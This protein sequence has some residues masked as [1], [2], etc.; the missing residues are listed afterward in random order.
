MNTTQVSRIRTWSSILVV[1]LSLWLFGCSTRMAK[2]GHLMIVGGGLKRENADVFTRMISL[3][4]PGATAG[5]LPTASGVPEETGPDY[6]KDFLRYGGEGRAEV[7]FITTKNPDAATSRQLAQQIRKHQI[8]FFTGGDQSRI[9]RVFR[10]EGKE[11][12]PISCKLS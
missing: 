10:P 3:P 12:F 9:T 8:L 2:R 7:I 5:I 11:S 4:G 6:A 1:L